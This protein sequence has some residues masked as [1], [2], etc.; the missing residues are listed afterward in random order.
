M[1]EPSAKYIPMTTADALPTV[2]TED[3]TIKRMSLIWSNGCDSY[4]QAYEWM[5]QYCRDNNYDAVVGV[6]FVSNTYYREISGT[7]HRIFDAYG[8]AIAW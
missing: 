2:Y 4:L 3:R 5:A 8:T 6:R 1:S 7:V